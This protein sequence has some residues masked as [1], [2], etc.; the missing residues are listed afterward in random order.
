MFAPWIDGGHPVF[1]SRAFERDV[2]LFNVLD[3]AIRPTAFLLL[4]DGGKF[5][6]ARNRADMAAWVWTDD[7]LPEDA[8][9]HV[10]ALLRVHFAGGRV[11]MTAKS[12]QAARMQAYF[13]GLCYRLQRSLGLSAYRLDT[14]NP[15]RAL[16]TARP[17]NADDLDTLCAY[18][19][20]FHRDC[21]GQE[22]R[23]DPREA[24]AGTIETLPTWVLEV[25]GAIASVVIVRPY[26]RRNTVVVNHVY[27]HPDFRGRGCAKHLVACAVRPWLAQGMHAVIYADSANP[28]SNAAY[29]SLG[30]R[31]TGTLTEIEMTQEEG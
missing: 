18:Q 1:T 9:Q 26:E 27:T 23:D 4:S 12:A 13:E 30:F 22:L 16:G 11:L 25:D 19:R 3:R 6:I 31:L 14:L 24:L 5:I 17:A 28:V 10:L 2:D 8:F 29:R 15:T 7:A 21:F 20:G